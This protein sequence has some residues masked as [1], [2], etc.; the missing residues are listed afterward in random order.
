MSQQI[1]YET[2]NRQEEAEEEREREK[3]KV[4]ERGTRKSGG[5]ELAK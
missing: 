1:G 4:K 2:E 3:E 5:A